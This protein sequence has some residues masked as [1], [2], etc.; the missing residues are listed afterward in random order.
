MLSIGNFDG[1]HR[2]HQLLLARLVAR[3]RAAGGPA[4]V[5]T[6]DP[7]PSRILAPDKSPP[8][9]NLP[10]E[11]A[12]LILNQGVDIV[13]LYPTDRE[14]LDLVP[15]AFFQRIVV[16]QI[17]A[18]GLVEGPNFFFGRNRAGNI[19][20]LRELCS[21]RGIEL[22]IVAPSLV[23]ESLISSSR[24]RNGILGGDVE[25]AE[26]MLG[27]PY[28]LTGTVVTG[29]QRGRTLGFPTANLG[30]IQTLIPAH[31]VYAASCH[32]RGTDHPAA[33]HIGPNPTF[34][35]EQSKVE[36]HILDFNGDLYGQE[37]SV[38]LLERLR[39]V[40]KF[41]NLQDIVSQI[42]QDIAG[43]RA[44]FAALS[45]AASASEDH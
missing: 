27:R 45:S 10:D 19:G 24:I 38:D 18:A 6:F 14:L 35:E 37:L 25:A 12:R 13:I 1:V 9:L 41:M 8:Q 2:G 40:K 16:D 22:E 34:A 5:L 7:P 21:A 29:S 15:E 11:K 43:T 44:R 33:V 20:V 3:A 36:V 17:A 42:E 26:R 28:R 23:N 4:I 39:G 32:L 31:G 30:Q